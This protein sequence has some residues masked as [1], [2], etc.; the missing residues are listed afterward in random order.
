M[1]INFWKLIAAILVCQ[2]AGII[3]SI[4]TISSIP[5]WYSTLAKPWFTPPNWAFGPVW[6]TLYALMGIA[7]YLIYET[8][9][10]DKKTKKLAITL[11]AIQLILNTLWSIVFFG[12]HNIFGGLAI[13]V[14]LWL[15]I[16]ATMV[17]FYEIN[18]TSYILMIPYLLWVS[19]ATA[20][21]YWV[22]VLN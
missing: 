10:K 9:V 2:M 14:F 21:T 8:K 12:A 11:F 7:I 3:G 6:I 1:K 22:W 18:K 17:K 5:S 19:L 4:F 16:A 20:L 13:I 15:F